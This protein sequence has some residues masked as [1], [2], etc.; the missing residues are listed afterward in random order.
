MDRLLR[1]F[2]LIRAPRCLAIDRDDLSWRVGQA[3][4]PG[5]KAGLEGPGVKGGENIAKVMSIA[6]LKN[7][8]KKAGWNQ[9]YL[10]KIINQTA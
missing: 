8:R 3:R 1:S 9:N 2:L 10:E 6:S 4:D 7:R 5:H